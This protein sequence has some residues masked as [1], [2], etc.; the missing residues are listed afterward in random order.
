MIGK[1]FLFLFRGPVNWRDRGQI[2]LKAVLLSLTAHVSLE[3]QA[4]QTLS[5][6]PSSISTRTSPRPG[7][8][9]RGS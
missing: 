7:L 8:G 6:M 1:A 9:V 3:G 4:G 2:K 5:Q